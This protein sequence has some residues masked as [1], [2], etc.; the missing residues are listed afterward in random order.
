VLALPGLA[1]DVDTPE[2]LAALRAAGPRTQSALLVAGWGS[3][4]E[5]LAPPAGHPRSEAASRSP[6]Q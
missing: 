4:T 1:L 6:L 2:D 3:R 5:P